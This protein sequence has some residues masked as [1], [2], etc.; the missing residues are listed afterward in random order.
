MPDVHKLE[1]KYGD[2][3][4]FTSLNTSGERR[5]AIAQKV[6]RTSNNDNVLNGEKAEVTNSR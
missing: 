1:E 5:I 2:K 4:K 6:L 3:I